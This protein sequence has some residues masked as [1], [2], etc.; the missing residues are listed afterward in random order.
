V[1]TDG[2][3]W[4]R[5]ALAEL[6]AAG[7]RPRAWR[8][9]VGASFDRAQEQRAASRSARSELGALTGSGLL[10]WAIVAV[11]GHPTLALVGAIWVAALGLMVDWHLGMLETPDGRR[12]HS[13]G[14]ANLLTIG[15]GAVL[16]LVLVLDADGLVVALVAL[17]LLDV[18]D[19][20]VAR[21]RDERTRLGAWLDGSIDTLAV[22][23]LVVGAA[24]VDA[25]SPWLVA[26]VLGRLATPWVAIGLRSFRDAAPPAAHTIR[27]GGWAARAPG[28]VAS[29]GL[30]LALLGYRAGAALMVVGVAAS[31]VPLTVALRRARPDEVG[32]AGSAG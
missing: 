1:V 26:L 6:R 17:G 30:V 2:E 32:A 8:R 7:F 14:I 31:F 9:F 16:P 20:A 19:G 13:L 15:R 21:A 10:A 22:L 4:T 24:R 11:G 28:L 18:A 25:V 29:A 27:A 3:R 12:L 23:G 5:D